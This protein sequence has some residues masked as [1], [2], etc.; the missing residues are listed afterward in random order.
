LTVAAPMRFIK[1]QL[2]R[3]DTRALA[4]DIKAEGNLF[5][6]AVVNYFTALGYKVE[7][8]AGVLAVAGTAICST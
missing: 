5:H 3:Y 8:R 1:V 6:Q 4:V 2:Q 7:R